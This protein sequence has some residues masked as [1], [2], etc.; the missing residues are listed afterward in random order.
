MQLVKHVKP[1]R[2]HDGCV[3]GKE[4]RKKVID[5]ASSFPK[6]VEEQRVALFYVQF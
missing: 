3:K 1:Y 4:V 5:V 2:L 6:D